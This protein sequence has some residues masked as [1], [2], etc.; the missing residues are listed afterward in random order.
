MSRA[1]PTLHPHAISRIGSAPASSSAPCPPLVSALL[2]PVLAKA[3]CA[4]IP[5]QTRLESSRHEDREESDREGRPATIR[6]ADGVL[7][8]GNARAL[9][10]RAEQPGILTVTKEQ[11]EAVPVVRDALSVWG[12]HAT[13]DMILHEKS[14][15]STAAEGHRGGLCIP[16]CGGEAGRPCSRQCRRALGAAKRKKEKKKNGSPVHARF[17][18]G[19]LVKQ[20]GRLWVC[21]P[22]VTRPL[23]PPVMPGIGGMGCDIVSGGA[24]AQGDFTVSWV[25]PGC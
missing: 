6:W 20:R 15:M 19:I 25:A 24:S 4:R 8:G 14:S 18:D 11:R 10:R 3:R 7:C 5:H 17:D 1:A 21:H 16:G 12:G 22:G 23:G 13:M 9:G 2:G